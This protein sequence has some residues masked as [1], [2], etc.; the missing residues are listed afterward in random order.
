MSTLTI[1][2][3]RDVSVFSGFEFFQTAKQRNNNAVEI[4]NVAVSNNLICRFVQLTFIVKHFNT[5]AKCC[6]FVFLALQPIVVVF[7]QPDSGL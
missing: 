1:Q 4:W 6:F 5:I 7:S 3:F 2:V